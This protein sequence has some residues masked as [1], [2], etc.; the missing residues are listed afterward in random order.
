MLEDH[1]ASIESSGNHALRLESRL[2]HFISL[3]DD[4]F[5]AN[6]TIYTFKEGITRI[7]REPASAQSEREGEEEKDVA[8]GG[9][10]D[11]EDDEEEE[12]DDDSDDE[13]PPQDIHVYGLGTER[14][15]AI[16]EFKVEHDEDMASLVEAVVLH[17]IAEECYVDGK[18]LDDSVRLSQG[19]VVQ[20][21]Q[22]NIFRFNHPTEAARLRKQM[23]SGAAVG[24][25]P[26][27][28]LSMFGAGVGVKD[29][30][31][32]ERERREEEERHRRAREEQEAREKEQLRRMEES[33][34]NER[35]RLQAEKV[36]AV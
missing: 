36:L 5:S 11:E 29:A 21:G 14:E 35:A 17:P 32:Q 3:S 16:I 24:N 19:N 2:P 25:M 4:P 30:A 18:K 20:L 22:T 27:S 7:G 26:R 8:D 12:E 10:D 1:A 31:T 23:S 33:L 9:D 13:T 6:I 15:H 34:E 28:I